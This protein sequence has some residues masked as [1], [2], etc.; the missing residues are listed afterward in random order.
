[1][2]FKIQQVKIN[3][4]THH[5]IA[6]I[7]FLKIVTFSKNCILRMKTIENKESQKAR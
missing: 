5:L 1:M 6:Q 2:F 3:L 7:F 4:S